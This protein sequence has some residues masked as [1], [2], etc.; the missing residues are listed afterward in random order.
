MS[1][2]QPGRSLKNP[3]H[4]TSSVVETGPGGSQGQDAQ[5][6]C[7]K[8]GALGQHRRRRQ[9]PTRSESLRAGRTGGRWLG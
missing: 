8:G 5:V 7:M 6:T 2:E 1:R 4:V 9:R 3:L